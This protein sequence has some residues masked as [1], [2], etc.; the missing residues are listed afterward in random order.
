VT[1]LATV[2]CISCKQ[3]GKYTTYT[4]SCYILFIFIGGEL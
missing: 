3:N 1:A 4:F 2:F